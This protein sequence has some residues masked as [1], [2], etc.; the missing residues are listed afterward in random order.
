MPAGEE[1]KEIVEFEEAA[2]NNPQPVHEHNNGARVSLGINEEI[3]I[4]ADEGQ[5]K[6]FVAK[7]S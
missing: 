3:I 1:S 4:S 6:G 2:K 7:G 5:S